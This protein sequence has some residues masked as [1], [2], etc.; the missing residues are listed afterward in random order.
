MPV[1]LVQHGKQIPKEEDPE[2]HLSEAGKQDTEAVAKEAS[3]K[4][5]EVKKILHS[6]KARAKETADAIAA[7]LAPSE[8]TE[9]KEGIQA[10]D[11]VKAAAFELDPSGNL[12]LV[13][14]LPFMEKLAA[15]L[16]T[17]DESRLTVKFQNGGI[18]CL[19]K[20]DEDDNWHVRWAITPRP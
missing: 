13:G 10:L 20:R 1:Y 19:D 16:V 15:F 2:Q 14:H 4:G 8:G 7:I 12:M 3:A 18:V 17:G 6:E 9:Q 5:V 11:D